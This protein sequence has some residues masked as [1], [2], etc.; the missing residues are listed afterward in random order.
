VAE[1]LLQKK[2]RSEIRELVL[3]GFDE[4]KKQEVVEL[5]QLSERSGLDPG[6]SGIAKFLSG[7]LGKKAAQLLKH[8]E[9]ITAEACLNI[10]SF[11]GQI[12]VW[13]DLNR[14][15]DRVFSLLKEEAFASRYASILTESFVEKILRISDFLKIDAEEFRTSFQTAGQ[16]SDEHSGRRVSA[17]S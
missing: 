12:G 8:P 14:A 9:E 2:L 1:L 13:L 6:K 10:Q 5:I 15:Q 16:G 11:A 4:K 7:E 3:S 17:V